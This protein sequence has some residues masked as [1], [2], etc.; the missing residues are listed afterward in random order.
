MSSG[1]PDP[2][3]L[4]LWAVRDAKKLYALNELYHIESKHQ[5]T[6]GENNNRNEKPIERRTTVVQQRQNELQTDGTWRVKKCVY[7]AER[8]KICETEDWQSKCPYQVWHRA[9]THPVA[10]QQSGWGTLSRWVPID[11]HTASCW[12]RRP[13]SAANIKHTTTHTVNMVRRCN[14]RKQKVS[15]YRT[16]ISLSSCLQCGSSLTSCSR[17]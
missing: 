5:Q 17:I 10:L 4:H 13:R 12:G 7:G 15:D 9:L 1:S 11:R 16:Y 8:N 6:D 2:S 3:I 14:F